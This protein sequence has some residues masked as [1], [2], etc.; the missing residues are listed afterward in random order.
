MIYKC[1]VCGRESTKKFICHTEMVAD[2]NDNEPMKISTHVWSIMSPEEINWYKG[3]FKPTPIKKPQ[4]KK[5]IQVQETPNGFIYG[6]KKYHFHERFIGS[7][8][9]HSEEEA[10]EGMKHKNEIMERRGF[11][12]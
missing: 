8:I 4:Q 7:I 11:I 6:V 1:P 5:I 3:M 2:R 10:I 12:F 9:F